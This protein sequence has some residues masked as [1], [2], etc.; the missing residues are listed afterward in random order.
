[1]PP[2]A[3]SKSPYHQTSEEGEGVQGRAK[4]STP[5]PLVSGVKVVEDRCRCNPW[6]ISEYDAWKSG[7]AGGQGIT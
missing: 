1:M 4:L 7:R 3:I 2:S 5:K 6:H